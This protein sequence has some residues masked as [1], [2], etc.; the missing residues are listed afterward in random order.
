MLS[1]ILHLTGILHLTRNIYLFLHRLTHGS[2]KSR[3]PVPVAKSWWHMP[4]VKEHTT[5]NSEM[6]RNL[7][8]FFFSQSIKN[9]S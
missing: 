6:A 9:S 7:L 5:H 2:G 4:I 8:F 3:Q 1:Y